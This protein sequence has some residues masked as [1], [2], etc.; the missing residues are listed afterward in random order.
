[1]F[2]TLDELAQLEHAVTTAADPGYVLIGPGDKVYRRDPDTGPRAVVPV[3]W[4]EGDTVINLLDH[5]HLL[6]SASARHR[7]EIDGEPTHG[8]EIRPRPR[9]RDLVR[10]WQRDRAQHARTGRPC[11]Y[12]DGHGTHPRIANATWT[13]ERGMHRP[14]PA[15]TPCPHCQNPTAQRS[16]GAR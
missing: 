6:S 5:R 1:M 11:R 2:S 7:V 15:V 8:H 9:V 3:G 14:A 10:R 16:G 12:C 13:P 4:V